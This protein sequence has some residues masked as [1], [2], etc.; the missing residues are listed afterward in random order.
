MHSHITLHTHQIQGGAPWHINI[1]NKKKYGSRNGGADSSSF[2]LSFFLGPGFTLYFLPLS[3]RKEEELD[4]F[5]CFFSHTPTIQTGTKQAEV[6]R[7]APPTDIYFLESMKQKRRSGNDLGG[8]GGN[9]SPFPE[10]F[11]FFPHLQTWQKWTK[12][13]TTSPPRPESTG[14]LYFTATSYP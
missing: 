5:L 11:F 14:L 3:P 8:G 13:F 12:F 4:R 7:H 10:T 9:V 1:Y 2:Y 6:S